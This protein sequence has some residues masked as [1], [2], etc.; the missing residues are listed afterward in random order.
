[1]TAACLSS[2]AGCGHVPPSPAVDV[3]T[4]KI[5]VGQ[6]TGNLSAHA[7]F[8]HRTD[9]LRGKADVNADV[10]RR[11][12]PE[13]PLALGPVDVHIRLVLVVETDGSVREVK[14]LRSSG[15]PELDELYSNAVR[16]WKF[17]PAKS[18][19]KSVAQAVHQPFRVK[20]D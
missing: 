6:P 19:G 16:T 7:E 17:S 11:Y 3:Y 13:L 5:D 14:V 10:T 8:P 4:Q 18:G 20:L 15:R 1:M 2:L 9:V 12:M